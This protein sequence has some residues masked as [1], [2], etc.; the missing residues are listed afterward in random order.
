M[1]SGPPNYK[2]AHLDYDAA[3]RIS[4]KDAKLFHAKGLAFEEEAERTGD[5]TLIDEAIEMY[6]SALELEEFFIS[7]RYHLGLMYH[8]I[9]R[10]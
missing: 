2:D 6:I 10:F 5:Q 1:N 7:S 3:I 4:P 8:K 9:F